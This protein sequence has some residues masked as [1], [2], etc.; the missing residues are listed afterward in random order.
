MSQEEG[1]VK[2]LG[3]LR[4]ADTT[5]VHQVTWPHEVIYSPSAKPAIYDQL[6]SMAF[7][8]GY[9]TVMSR[10]PPH[11]KVLMLSH[12]QELM[13]DGE[14]YGWPVVRA[15]HATWLHV[16]QGRGQLGVMRQPN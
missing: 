5:V 12:L 10:E 8:D 6:C 2:V 11:I 9:I 7:V 16:E 4:T 15:Y 14:H 13:E 1:G 3:K